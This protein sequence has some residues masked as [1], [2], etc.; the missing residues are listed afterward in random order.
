MINLFKISLLCLLS[1]NLIARAEVE[2]GNQF[3]GSFNFFGGGNITNY[4]DS[5]QNKQ[6]AF[7]DGNF[8]FKNFEIINKGSTKYGITV[9]LGLNSRSASNPLFVNEANF[10]T[11]VKDRGA[12]LIG[13]QN[14][15]ASKMRVDSTTFAPHTQGVN[16]GWQNFILYPSN[17]IITKQGL[18]LETGFSSTYFLANDENLVDPFDEHRYIQP[19]ANWSNSILGFSYISDR[20]SGLRFGFE[21]A[22]SNN[23]NLLL[24]KNN[25][26][27]SKNN[28]NINDNNNIY[29]QNIISTGLNYYNA[30]GDFEVLLSATYEFAQTKSNNFSRKDVNS[31]ALGANFSYLGVTL[32]GSF[33]NFG[34]SSRIKNTLIP[35]HN[36]YYDGDNIKEAGSSYAF[37]VGLG[38]SIDKYTTSVAFLKSNYASNEF[39]SAVFSLETKISVSLVSYTQ[40]A[41]YEFNQNDRRSGLKENGTIISVGAKYIF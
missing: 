36:S 29:L 24:Q 10:T 12:R 26:T 38:Y 6:Y 17:T 23:I 31:Y 11:I 2:S 13:L 25:L 39:W 15:I 34:K 1:F 20:F 18:G 21:Y 22:P 4:T 8:K 37:D 16:G 7:I 40:V 5:T 28:K 32:G 14:S 30:F 27:D 41:R 35:G 3:S 33:S 19:D 9:D